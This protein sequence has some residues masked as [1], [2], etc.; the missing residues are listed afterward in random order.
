MA[1][2]SLSQSPL[3]PLIAEYSHPR[4]NTQGILDC[5]GV[6]LEKAEGHPAKDLPGPEHGLAVLGEMAEVLSAEEGESS[7][8]IF[9]RDRLDFQLN[10]NLSLII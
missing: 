1:E 2:S 3:H 4:L 5:I 10:N 6:V 7:T 9:H 8:L